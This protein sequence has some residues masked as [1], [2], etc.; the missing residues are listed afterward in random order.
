M[1]KNI[2]LC[3]GGTGSKGMQKRG[4]NVYKLLEAVDLHGH[5]KDSRL[6]KQI[7]F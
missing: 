1:T 7:A 2:V 4:T 5:K 6:S 3:S